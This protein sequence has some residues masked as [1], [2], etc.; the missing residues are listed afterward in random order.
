[1]NRSDPYLHSLLR[2]KNTVFTPNDLALIWGETNIKKIHERARYY[3]KKEQLLSPRKGFYVK[4]LN[5]DEYELS[6]K[7]YTPS[8]ISLYTV[9]ASE[10]II[11][12]YYKTIYLMSYL[13]REINV[14]GQNYCYKKLKDITLTNAQGI[15][16]KGNYFIATK[17]RAFLDM[18]Y[19]MPNFYFDNLNSINWDKCY[20]LLSIYRNKSMKRTLDNYYGDWKE[21]Q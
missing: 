21:N 3:L 8:Y 10:G 14:D 5:F 18:V 7:I 4:N 19:L 9:L 2:A 6:N 1:M 13:S 16:N 20:E 15:N 11:F 17:E 12:Q